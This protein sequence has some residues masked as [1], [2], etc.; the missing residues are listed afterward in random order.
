MRLNHFTI[1]ILPGS[2]QAQAKLAEVSFILV[3]QQPTEQ[4]SI[5]TKPIQESFSNKHGAA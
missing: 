5:E 2:A 1:S 4:V 3:I